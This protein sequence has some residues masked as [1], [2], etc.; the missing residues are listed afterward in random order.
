MEVNVHYVQI[1]N[2]QNVIQQMEN[3][4]HVK[5]D[6]IYHMAAISGNQLP[7]EDAFQ[8]FRRINVEGTRNILEEASR[9]EI[10]KFI[11]LSSIAAMGIV[12]E[13]PISEKS[14]CNPILPYQVSKFE[15]EQLVKE[16][17]RNGFP[18]VILRP[19]KIYGIGE[20]EYSY[21]TIARQ[22]KKG[23]FPKVGKG[24]NY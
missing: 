6:I 21:L 14:D 20:H 4:H 1:N 2:V 18:A 5:M 23:F 12:R 16:Y 9:S 10:R 19:T 22:C 3:V 8:L 24:H 7:S 11:H 15:S 17:I 13:C